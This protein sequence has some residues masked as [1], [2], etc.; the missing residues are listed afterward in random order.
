MGGG[1]LAEGRGLQNPVIGESG[2]QVIGKTKNLTAEGGGATHVLIAESHALPR[3]SNFW[4][5]L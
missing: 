4:K 2:D 5:S 3:E 1:S